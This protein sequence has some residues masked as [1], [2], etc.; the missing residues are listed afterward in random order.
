MEDTVG[1]GVWAVT[2]IA[3]CI[4]SWLA[5]DVAGSARTRRLY[6]DALA[7]DHAQSESA[8][9][10]RVE[11]WALKASAEPAYL[12]DRSEYE[13]TPEE[14][15]IAAEQRRLRR[16]AYAKT[17]S[18]APLHEANA[19]S[20]TARGPEAHDELVLQHYRQSVMAMHRENL[21]LI[22]QRRGAPYASAPA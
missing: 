10:Y 3:P 12:A 18:L 1:F 13:P 6:D 22:E 2:V 21:R 8:Q 11:S 4:V 9:A 7:L 20:I 5:G 16:Q 14:Q 17:P 15:A 19:Q